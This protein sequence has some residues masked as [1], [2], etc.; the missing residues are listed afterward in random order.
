MA[1]MQNVRN[2]VNVDQLTEA[3]NA[4]RADPHAG[5]LEFTV[6]SEWK[7]GFKAQHTPTTYVV[8][9]ERG[10]H[11]RAFTVS[12]DE[13]KEILGQDSGISP[14]ET[15]L[16]SLASCLTV[17]YAANAAAMGI[18][19]DEVS[20][21]VTGKGNLSGFMAIGQERPGLSD[22]RVKAFVKSSA[23]KEKLL[24]LHEY[25]NVHSPIWDTLSRP[26]HVSSQLITK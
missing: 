13:P 20:F 24:A 18:D 10:R 9:R 1:T 26:V 2:G 14:A 15:I 8:G 7:G 23:P 4:V 17:G 6:R 16:A 11:E 19:L 22:I 12:T 5:D 25:V 3:V 21:E